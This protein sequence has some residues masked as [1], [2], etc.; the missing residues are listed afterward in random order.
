VGI[1]D[2]EVAI[3]EQCVESGDKIV[4]NGGGLHKYV[5]VN[6]NSSLTDSY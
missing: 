4:A 1:I 5:H 2:N 3:G 6:E